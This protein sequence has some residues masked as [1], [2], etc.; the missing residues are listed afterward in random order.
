MQVDKKSEQAQNQIIDIISST[1]SIVVNRAAEADPDDV[2]YQRDVVEQKEGG[3][4]G[5]A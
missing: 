1:N 3:Q 2:G 4:D 5:D